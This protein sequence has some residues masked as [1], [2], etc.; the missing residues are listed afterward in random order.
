MGGNG[1]RNKRKFGR[2]YEIVCELAVLMFSKLPVGG[3]RVLA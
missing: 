1:N 3:A 2:L